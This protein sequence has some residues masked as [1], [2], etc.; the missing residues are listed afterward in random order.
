MPSDERAAAATPGSREPRA[1]RRPR[2][3][4]PAVAGRPVHGSVPADRPRRPPTTGPRGSARECYRPN[5]ERGNLGADLVGPR[6]DAGGLAGG[7]RPGRISAASSTAT[8]GATGSPSRSTTRSCRSRPRPIGGPRSP[9]ACATSSC[10]SAGPRPG[11]WLPE[12]AVDLPTLRLLAEQGIRHTILAPWQAADTHVETRRPYRVELGGG[13]QIVVALYDGGLS[14]AVSFEPR[15]DGRRRRIRRRAGRARG[16]SREPCPTTSRR[17][18]SSRPTAS[19]TATTSRS[20]TCS[21]R[22]CWRRGVDER[23][24]LRRRQPRRGARPSRPR[25]RFRTTR[26][27]ERTSWSCHHGVPRWSGECPARRTGA[28]RGRSARRSTDWPAGIDAVTDRVA[29]GWGASAGSVGRARRLRGR[30]HRRAGAG[31]LR[32]ALARDERP[33][34][35]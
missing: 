18:W 29:A 24:R 35:P 28:G 26:I 2:P 27:V 6:P 20:A 15:R 5:A 11:V 12:T 10:G 19:C 16:S 33:T 32:G 13:R 1:P 22:A 8:P 7:R 9:G 17:W 21:W 23:S 14:A 4:L 34:R 31:C 30:G 3:L 25:A